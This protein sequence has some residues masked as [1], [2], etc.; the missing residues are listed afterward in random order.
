[1]LEQS[2]KDFPQDYNPPARLALA[3]SEMGRYDDALQ[4]ADRAMR[5]VY[6]PRKIQVFVTKATILG[7]KGDTEGEKAAIQDAIAY[8]ETLPKA[9]V[10]SRR[11]E[12]LKSRLA[13]LG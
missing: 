5:L 8:A 11:I 4:A 10:S 9:Q 1:M 12:S 7:K 3:F 2:E 13:K 6:G